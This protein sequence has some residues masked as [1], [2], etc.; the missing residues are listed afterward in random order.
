MEIEKLQQH[1]RQLASLSETTNPVISCYVNLTNVGSPWSEELRNRFGV[2]LDGAMS[3]Y[4][5]QDLPQLVSQIRNYLLSPEVK[6]VRGIALF[7]RGG[8]E[9]LWLPME[10]SVPVPTWVSIDTL[11]NIYHL[12]ELKDRYQRYVVLLSSK[13]SAR[14][15]DIALGEVSKQMLMQKPSLR[16]RVGR[17]WTRVHYQNHHRERG[18]QFFREKVEILDH[19]LSGKGS[20]CLILAG[21]SRISEEIRAALPKHLASLVVDIVPLGRNVSDDEIVTSTLQSFIAAQERESEVLV[22]RLLNAFYKDDLAAA[23]VAECLQSLA[24]HQ[25]D[26]LVIKQD[27]DLG[28]ARLCPAC[29]WAVTGRPLP[30]NCME[31]N[32]SLSPAHD[33][34]QE[35]VR[36]AGIA[37]CPVEIVAESTRLDAF[38]GVG[39][40]LRYATGRSKKRGESGNAPTQ[41]TAGM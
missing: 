24:R 12:V 8:R 29:G 28:R 33:A 2:I 39:C 37:G 7:A 18:L 27:G 35:L 16:K 4:E 15:F 31:C 5:S 20:A 38:G 3:T 13:N 14:I 40:L 23:G 25:T 6:G 34:R 41:F 32:G 19:L 26:V 30:D 36:L 17:E 1:I 22:D 11:P 9:P 21:D 10:F